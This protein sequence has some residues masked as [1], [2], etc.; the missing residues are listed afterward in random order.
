LKRKKPKAKKEDEK[1]EEVIAKETEEQIRREAEE[2]AKIDAERKAQSIA[3]QI[4]DKA[5]M[6][7]E[8]YAQSIIQRAEDKARY[9]AERRAKEITRDAKEKRISMTKETTKITDDYKQQE[10]PKIEMN[11]HFESNDFFNPFMIGLSLWQ[12]YFKSCMDL[13]NQF[14]NSCFKGN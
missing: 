5:K 12:S 2:K 14:V 11:K 10:S 3:Q 6:G 1:I 13:N 7:A 8:T 4:Q 9:D